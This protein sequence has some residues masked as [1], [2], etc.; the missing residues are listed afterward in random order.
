M[1]ISPFRRVE[2][3]AKNL[4]DKRKKQIER[5]FRNTMR[6]QGYKVLSLKNAISDAQDLMAVNKQMSGLG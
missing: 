4:M 5:D 1:I 2:S 6:F 3:R